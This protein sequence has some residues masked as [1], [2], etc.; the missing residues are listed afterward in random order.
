MHQLNPSSSNAEAGLG[1]SLDDLRS[2][3]AL[4]IDASPNAR[5]MLRGTLLELGLK[6]DQV[7]QAG[8][9]G[10]ARAM[11]EGG[12]YDIVL[13]DYHFDETELTGS[14][15]V[16]ELRQGNL[17][18]YSTVF[19]MVTSEANYGK[20][21]E[22][23][24]SALDSYLLKP[25]TQNSLTQRLTV[26]RQRKRSLAA[27][28]KALDDEDYDT[29]ATLCLERFHAKGDYWLY[30]ARIGGE[31]MLRL[32]R[33]DEAR[34][35]F[36]AVDATKALPWARLGIA[37]AQLDGGH[38][39]PACQTLESLITD[40]PNY[41]DAYDVLGRAYFQ[42]GQVERAYD[43]Y[44]K[45][46]SITPS[47]LTRLQKMGML[48]FHLGKTGEASHALERA[49]E[50]G[51]GSSQFDPQSLVLLAFCQ[52]DNGQA[53]ALQSAVAQIAKLQ[54]QTPRSAR[55]RRMYELL[56]VMSLLDR[57]V[58]EA[59][60]RIK[61]MPREFAMPDYDLE[62]AS[63]ML[64]L[65]MRLHKAEITID[66]ARTW[67]ERLARRF[68]TSKSAT[69]MLSL[70]VREHAD[71]AGLVKEVYAFIM[72][73]AAQALSR[74]KDGD[75]QGALQAL[76]ALATETGNLKLVDLCEM[77]LQRYRSAVNDAGLVT[78][79]Q[80]LRKKYGRLPSS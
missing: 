1:S 72:D 4:V 7:K 70:M 73:Q 77:V 28:F 20:V 6:S 62:A 67:V 30:A 66:E 56:H 51:A 11:L 26:A 64:G 24:E 2:A 14:D 74:S 55:L 35:L 46:V 33:F 53:K 27:I 52:F 31:L 78:Q 54:Q 8:R 39:A 3:R 32:G 48:A 19:I 16:A 41:A 13:C 58:P 49:A 38:V 37:Q 65:L 21:A 45:A 10:E 17:L 61:N 79:V 9:Y 5:S 44:R 76:L 43:I 25:H 23:A 63:N 71:Y 34:Q 60:R 50:L 69:D 40:N 36:Q 29:A 75:V 12:R 15:L 47:S 80:V 18:P 68:C 22:A 42:G 59:V 57:Q